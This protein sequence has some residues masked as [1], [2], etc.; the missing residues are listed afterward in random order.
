MATATIFY[1]ILALLVAVL[2]ALYQY[3][4]KS[5]EKSKQVL[6]LVVLRALAVFALL[7]LLINPKIKTLQLSELKPVLNIVVDNSTSITYAKKEEQVKNFV[8]TLRSDPSLNDKFKINFYKFSDQLEQLDSLTFKGSGTDILSSLKSLETVSKGEI[9]PGIIITD[10]NQTFGSSYEFFNSSQALYP[11]IVGDTVATD[12]LRISRVNSNTYSNLNNQF[13]VEVF[14]QYQGKVPVKKTFTVTQGDKTVYRRTLDFSAEKD[15]DQIEFNLPASSVGL[16]NYV[17]RISSLDQEK[18][19]VNNA[20]NFIV[21]VIDEQ[22]K[23]LILSEINHPDIGM[24][25]RS[26]ETNKQRK[27]IIENKLNAQLDLT[28]YQLVILYQPRNSFSQTFSDLKNSKTN[29]FIVSGTETDWSFLNGAQPYFSKDYITKSEEYT[30]EFNDGFTEFITEDLDFTE[31]PPLEDIYGLVNFKVPFKTVLFQNIASFQ[32][33]AP[34]LATFSNNDFRAAVLFGE[35]SWKWRL[36]TRAEDGNFQKFDHF[37][38]KLIQYLS[39]TKRSRQLELDYEKTVYANSRFL[40]KA[41]YFDATYTFDRNATLVLDLLHNDSKA[42]QSLP[43]TLKNNSFE[44]VLNNLPPGPYSFVVS[45]ENKEISKRGSF[46]VLDYD[47]EMQFNQAD[48]EAL[49]RLAARSEGAVFYPTQA[50]ELSEALTS[51]K[52]NFTIQ[53]SSEKIVSLIEW[54]WLLALVLFFLSLE[55]FIRKYKGLI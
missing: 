36:L 29:F 43:F 17:A 49:Q 33:E 47:I 19:L 23:I 42:S 34:L 46:T 8:E 10:G 13:P 54:K 32:T 3:Y 52:R 44:A 7:I 9:S 1:L 2:L 27:V 22:A 30:A 15:S 39:S 26:I 11:V 14:F 24:F 35:Q 50:S 18:N 53:K 48:T 12:D 16:H 41:Q 20:K 37:F 25:K 4:F 31:L 5:K 21:E 55:W 38:N 51:D 45:T 6:L 40:I 28:D